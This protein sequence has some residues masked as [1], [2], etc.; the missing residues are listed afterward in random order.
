MVESDGLF[1][2]LRSD[3]GA[4][5]TGYT[6]HPF[7]EAMR[8]GSLLVQSFRHYLVQDY[9]FLLQFARAYAL[10][11]YKGRTLAEMREGAAGVDAILGTEIG[12]H[13]R[14]CAGWGIS[15]DDLASATESRAT[16]AYTRFVLDCGMRGDLLDLK[17]ALAPCVIGYAEIASR[18]AGQ[19][20]RP[21]T[22]HPYG[23]WIGEYSGE[24]YRAVA[25]AA[26]GALDRLGRI[27]LTTARYPALRETF[28]QAT[29]LEA[30]FWQMGLDRS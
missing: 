4:A 11:V 26:I 6:H 27:D 18:L 8:D 16:I 15:E 3:A 29:L 17:V 19:I 23:A 7:V 22:A 5:W 2:R 24:G 13:V 30:D 20:D 12:L 10:A 28:R 25:A 21:L 9:L 14:L 1:A